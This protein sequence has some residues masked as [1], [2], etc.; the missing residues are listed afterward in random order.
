M[1]NIDDYKESFEKNLEH[2]KKELAVIRTGRA[3]PS[4]VENILIEA[5]NTKMPLKQLSII[6]VTEAKSLVIQPWDKTI[7]KEI[8]KQLAQTNLE[9]TVRNEGNL[10]RVIMPPL[11]EENRKNLVKILNQKL[12]NTRI[13]IRGLRDEIRGKILTAEKNKEISEDEKFR[14]LEKLDTA[15]KSYINKVEELGEKKKEEIL[16]I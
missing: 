13:A 16:T 1:I 6:T 15:T 12:E 9:A 5:Y 3:S 10:L 8:E 14:L 11:T 4:L 2:L 7:I